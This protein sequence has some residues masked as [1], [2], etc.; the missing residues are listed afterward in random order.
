MFNS[1]NPKSHNVTHILQ[2]VRWKILPKCLARKGQIQVSFMVTWL[3]T[4]VNMRVKFSYHDTAK[5]SK[6]TPNIDL[7][8]LAKILII[9]GLEI[10]LFATGV[11]ACLHDNKNWGKPQQNPQWVS[12]RVR[13]LP[14]WMDHRRNKGVNTNV[15][16]SWEVSRFL[17]YLGNSSNAVTFGGIYTLDWTHILTALEY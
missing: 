1:G 10:F 17:E 7:S 3:N 11:L 12:L 14:R 15:I 8:C 2:K 6:C 16:F 4:Y 5:C 9:I 13:N